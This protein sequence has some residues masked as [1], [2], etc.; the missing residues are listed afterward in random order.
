MFDKILELINRKK[1]SQ[2]GIDNKKNVKSLHSSGARPF[3]EVSKVVPFYNSYKYVLFS[4]FLCFT[5]FDSQ[6]HLNNHTHR[7]HTH[8]DSSIDENG[9]PQTYP[10]KQPHTLTISYLISIYYH[11]SPFRTTSLFPITFLPFLP[12]TYFLPL[13]FISYRNLFPTI[14]Q[15]IFYEHYN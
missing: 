11:I 15:L 2:V 4:I 7:T 9:K 12:H 3:W 8:A 14:L 10:V 1:R 5:T 13:F 6:I